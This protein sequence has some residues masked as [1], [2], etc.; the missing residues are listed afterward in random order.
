MPSQVSDYVEVIM[1]K[2]SD[3][4]DQGFFLYISQDVHSGHPAN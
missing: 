2:G 4:E 3:P 1:Q